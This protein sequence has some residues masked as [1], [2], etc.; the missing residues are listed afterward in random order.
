MQKKQF[1]VVIKQKE[2]LTPTILWIRLRIKDPETINFRAGQYVTLMIPVDHGY[3][4]RPFSIASSPGDKKHVEIIARLIGGGLASTFLEKSPVNSE[5]LVE[6]P[7][8]KFFL[9]ASERNIYLITSGSGIAPFR[10]MLYQLFEVEH[11]R[12]LVTLVFIVVRGE[13]DFLRNELRRFVSAHKNLRYHRVILDEKA[14]KTEA[15]ILLGFVKR[16]SIDRESDF[17][18]CGGVNFVRDASTI[19]AGEG[20]EKKRIHFEKF[21]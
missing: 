16:E 9:R 4:E 2:R 21:I 5:L 7:A 13:E 10:A 6:G 12:R 15:G 17:Y 11:T 19:L 1:R 18:L 8:G 3:M 20:I 14:G